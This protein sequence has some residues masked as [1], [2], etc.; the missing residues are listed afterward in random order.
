MVSSLMNQS[1]S[2]VETGDTTNLAATGNSASIV[3][4]HTNVKQPPN[5]IPLTKPF[6]TTGIPSDTNAPIARV[7]PF[8]KDWIQKHS[9]LPATSSVHGD[10]SKI[11]EQHQLHIQNNETE[12]PGGSKLCTVANTAISMTVGEIRSETQQFRHHM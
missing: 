3:N 6:M 4:L 12:N 1:N 5:E 7:K 8:V 9:T 10:F 2:T 11:N